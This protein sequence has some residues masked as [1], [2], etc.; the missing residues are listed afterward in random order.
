M[1]NRQSLGK[2]HEGMT[3]KYHATEPAGDSGRRVTIL[4]IDGGG[5]RGVIPATLL[6]QLEACLQVIHLAFS[7]ALKRDIRLLQYQFFALLVESL[8]DAQN[9][10]GGHFLLRWHACGGYREHDTSESRPSLTFF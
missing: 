2:K 10:N 1:P 8:A 3:G 9:L 7:F 6:Q 4:S 5:V